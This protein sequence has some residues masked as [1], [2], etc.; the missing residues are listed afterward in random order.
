[1]VLAYPTPHH[2]RRNFT[3]F[4]FA[5]FD[6]PSPLFP[7]DPASPL[8]PK[9][10]M[11]NTTMTKQNVDYIV[12]DFEGDF[13]GFQAYVDSLPMDSTPPTVVQSNVIAPGFRP[14]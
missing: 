2:I 7:G 5:I 4:P 3:V 8:L 1:M 9:G 11:V 12:N 14:S 10:L 13:T 6:K